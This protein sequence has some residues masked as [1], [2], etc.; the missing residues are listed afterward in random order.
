[1]STKNYVGVFW[2][3]GE[4][5]GQ[6]FV[7]WHTLVKSRILNNLNPKLI[8]EDVAEI[9]CVQKMSTSGEYLPKLG[10][11]LKFQYDLNSA[12][13]VSSDFSIGCKD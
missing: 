5:G 12:E 9:S 8:F 10:K 13:L 7:Q 6:Y 4:V 2:Q 11:A 3:A 1:M